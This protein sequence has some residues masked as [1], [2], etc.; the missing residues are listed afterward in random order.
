MFG[1]DK[2]DLV[3][4]VSNN[5]ECDGIFRLVGIDFKEEGLTMLDQMI[6]V[7]CRTDVFDNP[8]LSLGQN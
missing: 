6:S 2:R 8:K 7:L 5:L 1:I 4:L 3:P